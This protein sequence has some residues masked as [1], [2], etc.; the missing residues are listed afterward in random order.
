MT[1]AHVLLISLLLLPSVGVAAAVPIAPLEERIGDR[2]F[3]DLSPRSATTG[4]TTLIVWENAFHPEQTQHSVYGRILAAEGDRFSFFIGG[5]VYPQVASNG[6]EYLVAY[7]LATSRFDPNPRA[8]VRVQRI[9]EDGALAEVATIHDSPG[10]TP[11]VGDLAWTGDSWM[12]AFSV[13]DVARIAFVGPGLEER[14]PTLVLGEGIGPNLVEIDGRWWAVYT[15]DGA[16]Q[17]VEVLADG[18]AGSRHV[19]PLSGGWISPAGTT[20]VALFE[21]PT[22]I[23]SARFDPDEGFSA[24][25]PIA[26][27]GRIFDF[28]SFDDTPIA[29]VQP[30]HEHPGT[31]LE[32]LVLNAEGE[33]AGRHPLL[34]ND[35]IRDAALGQGSNGPILMVSTYSQEVVE[36]STGSGIW[37]WPFPTLP[38]APLEYADGEIVSIQ[39]FAMQ[40]SPLIGSNGETLVAFWNQTV[41]DLGNEA[42]FSRL[43]DESGNPFGEVTRLPFVMGRGGSVVFD[44]DRFLLIWATGSQR[45]E[46]AVVSADGRTGSVFELGE[47]LEPSIASGPDGAFAVW[48][49]NR[50]LHE[51]IGTP[52]LANGSAAVPGGFPILPSFVENQH[53]PVIAPIDQGFLVLWRGDGGTRSV[54]I[55]PA[56]APRSSSETGPL[57][58]GRIALASRPGTALA[59]WRGETGQQV[60]VEFGENGQPVD[61]FDPHWGAWTPV[62]I[63][64]RPDGYLVVI[65]KGARVFTSQLSLTGSFI[66]GR[67]PLEHFGSVDVGPGGVHQ[68]GLDPVGIWEQEGIVVVGSPEVR[69]RAA[70]R[71]P[72]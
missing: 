35:R 31:S 23:L 15:S 28:D 8:R 24:P 46:A 59:A 29:L 39:Q 34:E 53:W 11:Y 32:A 44:R 52:L 65:R 69:R 40:S 6:S 47:G 48:R 64:P 42:T 17:A 36:R 1:P 25:Q 54:V 13:S 50:S 33:L 41:D 49:G 51:I 57:A 12:I 67:T 18:T 37:V 2:A 5:N 60:I 71:R 58:E 56:G 38:A 9:L 70:S 4:Q 66:T 3:D 45:I 10:S 72:H 61:L 27:G 55:S 30:G 68:L 21:T 16:M 20:G 19:A 43:V 7:G 62:T 22:G 14:R 63:L 26:T